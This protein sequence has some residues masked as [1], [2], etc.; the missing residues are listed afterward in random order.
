LSAASGLSGYVDATEEQ[1]RFAEKA[2][3]LYRELGNPVEASEAFE[4]L[5]WAQLQALRLEA[6]RVSLLEATR[7]YTELGNRH[8]AAQCTLALSTVEVLSGRPETGR[9]LLEEA[10][11]TFEELKDTF[12]VAFTEMSVG[13]MD[14]TAGDDQTAEKRYRSS[15]AGFRQ[16]DSLMG[17]TWTLYGFADLALGRGEYERALRLAAV[18]DAL[19]ERL[20]K[21]TPVE[22]ALFGDVGLGARASLNEGT[23]ERA[24]RQGLAMDLEEAVAYALL[25]ERPSEP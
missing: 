24:Y 19:R 10:L 14:K 12:W 25:R 17:T 3:A 16:L 21:P 2:A 22:K 7:R 1:L 20:G 8:K 5:G 13:H 18:C 15:L 4:V 11:A 6:A 23:A 9:P